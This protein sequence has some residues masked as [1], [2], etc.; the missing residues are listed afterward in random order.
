ME[1]AGFA[2]RL[3]DWLLTHC[4]FT[5]LTVLTLLVV[6]YNLTIVRPV[7]VLVPVVCADIALNVVRRLRRVRKADV[8][9]AMG[10]HAAA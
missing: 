5:A 8:S 7:L 2:D 4:P 1:R 6:G 10:H 9:P 3:T